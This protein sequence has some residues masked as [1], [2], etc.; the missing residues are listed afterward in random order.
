M[1]TVHAYLFGKL[2]Y[3]FFFKTKFFVLKLKNKS[4]NLSVMQV[5]PTLELFIFIF[6]CHIDAKCEFMY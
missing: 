4:Q 6:S 3:I 1:S 2:S 5:S